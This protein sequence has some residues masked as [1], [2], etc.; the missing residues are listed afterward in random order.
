VIGFMSTAAA[1]AQPSGTKSER[2]PMGFTGTT[3]R[4]EMIVSSECP[5]EEGSPRA[6]L[7]SSSE[8]YTRV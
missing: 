7:M 8:D 6:W 4:Y 2:V 1:S 5:A 3:D